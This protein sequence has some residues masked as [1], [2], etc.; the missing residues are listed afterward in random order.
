MT[1]YCE[2][3]FHS[4][5]DEGLVIRGFGP[6]GRKKLQNLPRVGDARKRAV[7]LLSA[8]LSAR[9]LRIDGEAATDERGA[10]CDSEMSRDTETP[11]SNDPHISTRW[12]APDLTDRRQNGCA[13]KGRLSSN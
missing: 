10:G 1:R 9:P 13:G 8:P 6:L 5:T 3:P 11:Q 4:W 12:K 7:G 2:P